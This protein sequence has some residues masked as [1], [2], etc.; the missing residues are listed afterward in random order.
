MHMKVGFIVWR[1]LVLKTENGTLSMF[2]SFMTLTDIVFVLWICIQTVK[3]GIK[4]NT[5]LNRRETG[6]K[7]V[8]FD[9]SGVAYL[10]TIK[11]K[12]AHR[13]SLVDF[14]QIRLLPLIL[15]AGDWGFR[16]IKSRITYLTWCW[17]VTCFYLHVYMSYDHH[18]DTSVHKSN[19][20]QRGG[21]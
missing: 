18:Y 1:I 5:W 15:W 21:H 7:Q 17:L 11:R 12:A 4:A 6:E 20:K 10:I 19:R 13:L 14:T 8:S 2:H 3:L 16:R 9:G